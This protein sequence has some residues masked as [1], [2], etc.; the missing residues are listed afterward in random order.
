M[1]RN[2]TEARIISVLCDGKTQNET[3]VLSH[4]KFIP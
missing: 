3:R 1:T 2:P 4:M